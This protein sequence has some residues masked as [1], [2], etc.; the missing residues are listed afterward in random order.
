[1]SFRQPNGAFIKPGYNPVLVPGAP[2]IGA[3]TA[4]P[5][6]VIVAF[7][8]PTDTGGSAI[9]SYT[10]VSTPDGITASGASSPITVTG[11]TTGTAYT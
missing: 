5:N 10:A 11:L 7:T 8:A 1:M 3:V 9:T 4:G 2:T 6:Q